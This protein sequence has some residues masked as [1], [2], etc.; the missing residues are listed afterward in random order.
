[1]S[2]KP[3]R[4]ISIARGIG[5]GSIIFSLWLLLSNLNLLTQIAGFLAP[6]PGLTYK[7]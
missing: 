3:F 1:M 4:Q 2:L 7:E 5:Q 6:P